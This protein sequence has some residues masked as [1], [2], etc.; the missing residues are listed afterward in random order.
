MDSVASNSRHESRKLLEIVGTRAQAVVSDGDKTLYHNVACGMGRSFIMRELRSGHL[1]TTARGMMG[2]LRVRRAARADTTAESDDTAGVGLFYRELERA[3]IGTRGEMGGMAHDFI[4]RNRI[5]TT[6]NV[7][8]SFERRFLATC[9]GS[10]VASAAK[11]IF[12]FADFVSNTD[13]FGPDGLIT[14]VRTEIVNGEQK[15]RQV[16]DML[17]RHHLSLRNCIYIGDSESDIPTLME[18]GF[19]VASPFATDDVRAVSHYVLEDKN[20]LY[21]RITLRK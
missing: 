11:E 9:N 16:H 13:L 17:T 7:V 2:Y 20:L 8:T 3:G 5:Y 10:T 4:I 18:A 12:G 19:P 1:P 14:G 6:W 15:L 21:P